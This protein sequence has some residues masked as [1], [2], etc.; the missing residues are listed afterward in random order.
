MQQKTFFSNTVFLFAKRSW[1]VGI[2]TFCLSQIELSSCADNRK[3]LS[4][5]IAIATASSSM[6]T[7]SC[8]PG[9]DSVMKS[10]GCTLWCPQATV[11]QATSVNFR[12][13]FYYHLT[14]ITL[15]QKIPK[16]TQNTT[17]FIKKSEKDFVSIAPFTQR[18]VSLFITKFKSSLF[19]VCQN[20]LL[21]GL[22]QL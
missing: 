17:I 16:Q 14:T 15:T 18:M 22:C 20:Y 13:P 8:E 19:P 1:C 7:S 10:L 2:R 6:D 21:I 3:M 12:F 4:S 5:D 11:G 9:G